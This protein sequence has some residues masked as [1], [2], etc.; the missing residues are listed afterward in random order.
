MDV[1]TPTVALYKVASSVTMPPLRH[2]NAEKILEVHK[3]NAC[4]T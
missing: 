4:L 2:L 1:K 3:N